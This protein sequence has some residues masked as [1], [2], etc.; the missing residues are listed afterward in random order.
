M[1]SPRLRS[2]IAVCALI[3]A[4]FLAIAAGRAGRILRHPAR[5]ARYL[6][7]RTVRRVPRRDPDGEPLDR[8]EMRAFLGIVEC[9][10]YPAP[11]QAGER[12]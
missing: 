10:K 1:P 2:V 4:T 11:A 8:D 12:A 5:Y 7:A 9:W 6:A 3:A